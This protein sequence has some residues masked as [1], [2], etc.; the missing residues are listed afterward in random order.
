MQA[1]LGPA[2]EQS[3]DIILIEDDDGHA[4]LIERNLRRAGLMN[5]IKRLADGQKA[6]IISSATTHRSCAMGRRLRSS[7]SISRCRASTV[8]KCCAA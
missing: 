8:S 4:K 6:L 7:S 2:E 1:G 5:D 3:V